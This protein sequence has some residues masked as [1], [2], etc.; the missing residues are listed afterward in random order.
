MTESEALLK[1]LTPIWDSRAYKK[2]ITMAHK[3]VKELRAKGVEAHV[4]PVENTPIEKIAVWRDR[5]YE[6]RLKVEPF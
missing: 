2:K 6:K 3:I 1:G 4:I 5:E